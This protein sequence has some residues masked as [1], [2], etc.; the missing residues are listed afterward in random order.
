MDV[1]KTIEFL[2]GQQA[3]HDERLAQLETKVTHLATIAEMQIEAHDRLARQTA[4]QIGALAES[5]R[6]LVDSQRQLAESQR[7]GEE[8]A[9]QVRENLNA[10]IRIVDE[11]IR[12]PPESRHGSL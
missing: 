7:A 6:Q 2:L 12:R 8:S 10:L 11:L 5:Q 1:E 9:A 3:G 4:A